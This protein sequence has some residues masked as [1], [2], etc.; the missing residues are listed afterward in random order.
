MQNFTMPSKSSMTP[1]VALRAIMEELDG[2][3]TPGGGSHIE[4]AYNLA[5][6]VC[7]PTVSPQ[8][9]AD[10]LVEKINAELPM[11]EVSFGYIGNL[12]ARCDDRSWRF[13]MSD[14][15]DKPCVSYSGASTEE[16]GEFVQKAE[17]ELP[18][19]VVKTL[20]ASDQI[21]AEAAFQWIGKNYDPS[22]VAALIRE[23][24][25]ELDAET[26]YGEMARDPHG[27]PGVMLCYMHRFEPV[28]YLKLRLEAEKGV[29]FERAS[30]GIKLHLI[31][32]ENGPQ[33]LVLFHFNSMEYA[34]RKTA[35]ALMSQQEVMRSPQQV[36]GGEVRKLRNQR[37]PHGPGA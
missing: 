23:G 26:F 30:G 28:S 33:D 7:G 13:F 16:L 19:W 9:R 8:S 10:A 11:A 4:R 20:L 15:P 21:D 22:A 36:I 17:K 25:E 29:Q 34:V 12:S 27:L 31:P 18:A 6:A 37:S 2:T 32:G 24:T 3:F 1:E 5:K 14:G 35:D